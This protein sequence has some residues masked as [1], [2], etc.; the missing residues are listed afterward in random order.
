MVATW[1]RSRGHA[2]CS[3]HDQFSNLSRFDEKMLDVGERALVNSVNDPFTL[4]CFFK[5]KSKFQ[6]I[7]LDLADKI[8]NELPFRSRDI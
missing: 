1:S 3:L 6:P 8:Q 2:P 7:D 5:M 4:T